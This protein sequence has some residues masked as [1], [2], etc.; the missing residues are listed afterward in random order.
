MIKSITSFLFALAF[1]GNVTAQDV[2]GT[3]KTIDDKTGVEKSIVEIFK[4]D[5]MAYGKILK[6]LDPNAPK[7]ATC[8]NC[9]GDDANVP[10][11]GLVFI[12]DLSK[13][14][15]EYTDGRV[16]DP[17]SGKVYKCYIALEEPNKLKVRGYLGFSLL[18]RTQYW[19]RAD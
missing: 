2:F 9:P 7:N 1:F 11:I 16:L 14:G 10:I 12:K 6:L 3:W 5:G 4:K 13:D 19:Y 15:D 8:Q 18:G 17:E